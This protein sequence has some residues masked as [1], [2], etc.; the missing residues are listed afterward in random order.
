[1]RWQERVHQ[2]CRVFERTGSRN[3]DRPISYSMPTGKLT[4]RQ[5]TLLGFPDVDSMI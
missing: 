4:N 3:G 5:R 2:L 1:M